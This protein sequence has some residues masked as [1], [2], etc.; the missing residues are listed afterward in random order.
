[1]SAATAVATV[2]TAATTGTAATFTHS[3]PSE[4]LARS[5]ICSCRASADHRTFVKAVKFMVK[6]KKIS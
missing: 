4:L 2:A 5:C 6:Y 1:M 3:S